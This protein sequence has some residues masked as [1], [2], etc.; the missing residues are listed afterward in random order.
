MDNRKC[1]VCDTEK[2]ASD[3][4]ENKK[5]IN[6]R[7]KEC[8]R[9]YRRNHYQKT[10]KP[11]LKKPKPKKSKFIKPE[12][13]NCNIK[14]SDRVL[15]SGDVVMS[16]IKQLFQEGLWFMVIQ[17]YYTKIRLKNEKQINKKNK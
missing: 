12:F 10:K 3:F 7:C 6:Y 1:I 17:S 13:Y 16:D 14:L 11:K 4:Y 5:W 2:E 15:F 8:V 9:K